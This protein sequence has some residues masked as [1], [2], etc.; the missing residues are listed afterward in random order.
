MTF[1][2][3]CSTKR[4]T[5]RYQVNIH[6]VVLLMKPTVPT[7]R[8]HLAREHKDTSQATF[9]KQK[10]FPYPKLLGPWGGKP[11]TF[12]DGNPYFMGI[13]QPLRNW[14]DEFIPYYMEMS[15]EFRLDPIAH[16]SSVYLQVVLPYQRPHSH[17]AWLSCIRDQ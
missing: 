5:S 13:H 16:I 1:H 14:V 12:N 4:P 2:L 15:W 3:V 7:G 17:L 11:P 9:F 6:T 8:M 10:M